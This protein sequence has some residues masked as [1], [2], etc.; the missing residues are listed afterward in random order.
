MIQRA[1]GFS[2]MRARLDVRG[3][4]I[5]GFAFGEGLSSPV[6]ADQDFNIRHVGYFYSAGAVPHTLEAFLFSTSAWYRRPEGSLVNKS[7]STAMG[8]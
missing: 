6:I 1:A 2:P 8:A 7:T 4:R 3:G 5:E